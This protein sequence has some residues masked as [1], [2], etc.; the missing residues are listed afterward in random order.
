MISKFW[1]D[2]AEF[3]EIPSEINGKQV[4]VIG[5]DAFSSC[6]YLSKIT[7]PDNLTTICANAFNQCMSISE[8]NIPKTV[9]KIESGSFLDCHYLEK[10]NISKCKLSKI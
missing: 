6:I 3:V 2:Q 7:F 5:P 8:L 9:T 10:I 1:Q 4:T